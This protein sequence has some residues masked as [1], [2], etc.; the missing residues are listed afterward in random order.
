MPW[1]AMPGG[2][3]LRGGGDDYRRPS[4]S[5]ESFIL[6]HMMSLDGVVRWWWRKCVERWRSW[7]QR[8]LEG[9]Y[10]VAAL[11]I[12]ACAFG[13][14][15]DKVALRLD[16]K[17]EIRWGKRTANGGLETPCAT[18]AAVELRAAIV[19]QLT[20][21][22]IDEERHI[23]RYGLASDERSVVVRY[24]QLMRVR[25][26][27]LPSLHEA[28]N[29]VIVLESEARAVLERYRFE[30]QDVAEYLRGLWGPL[31]AESC[32][33]LRDQMNSAAYDGARARW[34]EASPSALTP[35][36]YVGRAFRM[37]RLRWLRGRM[38]EWLV[39][40]SKIRLLGSGF[41][42]TPMVGI[43]VLVAAICIPNTYMP[44]HRGVS[45]STAMENRHVIAGSWSWLVSNLR[46][47]WTA[48]LQYRPP[49]ESEGK[50][51]LAAFGGVVF[52]GGAVMDFLRSPMAQRLTALVTFVS[53]VCGILT[54]VLPF[55]KH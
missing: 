8:R 33:K 2:G 4:F 11:T 19:V 1:G 53:A 41:L 27:R 9:S 28:A 37:Q 20:G 7:R 39:S 30:V 40:L 55:F 21:R 44:F 51:F 49:S 35:H 6:S 32:T 45:T 5:T 24:A 10:R 13:F 15:V 34:G 31:D 17:H 25:D 43:L 26:G 46:A 54:L 12:A 36:I 3:K 16:G 47:F 48:Y 42:Y 50:A 52:V 14:D 38:Q 23:R 18:W 22:V 29:A